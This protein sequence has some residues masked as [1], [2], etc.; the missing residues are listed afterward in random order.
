MKAAL[1]L[2]VSRPHCCGS[3][4]VL[5]PLSFHPPPTNAHLMERDAQRQAALAVIR[6]C[7]DT[8][9][10][11]RAAGVNDRSRNGQPRRDQNIR[12]R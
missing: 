11:T 2:F 7:G 5:D 3:G 1:I 6:R 10:T 9:W 4:G 8:C 12:H